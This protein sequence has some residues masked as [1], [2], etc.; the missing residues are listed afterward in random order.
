MPSNLWA[1]C[2]SSRLLFARLGEVIVSENV[3]RMRVRDAE[4]ADVPALIAIK[5]DGSEALHRDRLRDAE[6]SGFRY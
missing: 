6:G 5:G 4:E 3:S 2:C 1:K